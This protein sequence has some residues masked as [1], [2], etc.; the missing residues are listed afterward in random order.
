ME[1]VDVV[2]VEAELNWQSN[3]TA[4][5]VTINR[6][7]AIGWCGDDSL[8]RS[9]SDSTVDEYKYDE[10]QARHK[11]CCCVVN[12]VRDFVIAKIFGSEL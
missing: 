1:A 8:G 11:L 2:L 5:D 3:R 10:I 12:P 4:R 6:T 9:T 7:R